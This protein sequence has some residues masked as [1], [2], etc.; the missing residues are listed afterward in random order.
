MFPPFYL[1]FCRRI[2][3]VFD[4]ALKVHR[5]VQHRDLEVGRNLGN[6]I[7]RWLDRMKPSAQIRVHPPEKPPIAGSTSMT[8]PFMNSSSQKTH[9]NIQRSG[10]K[11]VDRE[12]DRHLFTS[13]THIWPKPFPSIAKMM[14]PPGTSIQCRHLSS[15]GPNVLRPN[16][17]IYGSEGVIRRDI[18]QWML[19]D[20]W[21]KLPSFWF[22]WKVYFLIQNIMSSNSLLFLIF[23]YALCFSGGVLF[24][25][26]AMYNI[27]ER[28]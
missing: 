25:F 6:R 3:S 28:I 15:C 2:R 10:M 18:L 7:L 16:Y 27:F 1:F 14:R 5:N 4:V 13:Q 26:L 12:S 21:L 9:T 24:S 8:K 11:G 23:F 17:G 22:P 20:W 19:R